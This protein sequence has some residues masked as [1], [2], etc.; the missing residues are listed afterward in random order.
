MTLVVVHEDDIDA[1][2]SL[3]GPAKDD[4]RAC[5]LIVRPGRQL[6]RTSLGQS[7]A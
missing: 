2:W 1:I 3:V 5:R 6:G 4:L 7:R